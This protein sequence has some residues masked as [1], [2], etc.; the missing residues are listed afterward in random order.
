MLPPL[1]KIRDHS[2]T[3]VRR[4]LMQK[5]APLKVLTLLRGLWKISHKFSSENWVYMNFY[6][7]DPLIIFMSKRGSWNFKF[8]KGYLVG[9]ILSWL[10]ACDVSNGMPSLT[11]FGKRIKILKRTNWSGQRFY[12]VNPSGPK[13]SGFLF[14]STCPC[15][16]TFSRQCS[17][18]LAMW[19]K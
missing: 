14:S 5:G 15:M 11:I 13:S 12:L 7:V 3:F 4:A 8:W 17:S 9:S 2:Q 1:F 19:P 18:L 10:T 16:M 6:G